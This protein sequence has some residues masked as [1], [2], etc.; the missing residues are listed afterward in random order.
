MY[1]VELNGVTKKF[2][3]FIALDNM[4]LNIKEGEIYGL[5]G[6]NGA[7][8]STAIKLICGILNP[9]YGIVKVMG[10]EVKPKMKHARK[11]L[12]LV[13]QEVAIYSEYT[14]YEN[15]KFFTSLYGFKGKDLEDKIEN[16]LTFTGLMDVKNKLASE[17]SGGMRRRLNIACGIAHEPKVVIMDEPTV[18]IDPQSRNYILKAI[19]ELNKKGTTIIY[20]THYMEE[21]EEICS[22]IGIIDNG[23]LIVQGNKEE[24]KSLVS[25]KKNLRISINNFEEINKDEIKNI[26]GVSNIN[27][28]ENK[29]IITSL[30]E[31]NN[32]DKI[33]NYFTG[34][35]IEIR[36]IDYED[37]SLETVFL[38]LTG[39]SLRE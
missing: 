11:N 19:K 6:P 3:E 17:F 16:A 2:G 5:L 25:D 20:T 10:K 34:K 37:V 33:I 26:R 38:S 39:K 28:Y 7:G 23:K 12:G 31:V 32:L 21:A 13:P 8:K 4:S 35:D 27:V 14:A 22:N 1:V 24:L 29:V 30:K 36:D 18:G 15:I 9:S